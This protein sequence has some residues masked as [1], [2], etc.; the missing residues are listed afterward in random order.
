MRFM[1]HRGSNNANATRLLGHRRRHSATETAGGERLKTPT[2]RQTVTAFRHYFRE[3]EPTL[4]G[5]KF[6]ELRQEL[7]GDPMRM[8]MYIFS[9]ICQNSTST[10]TPTASPQWVADDCPNTGALDRLLFHANGEL[11]APESRMP[12]LRGFLQ[13]L[14]ELDAESEPYMVAGYDFLR[15]ARFLKPV[16]EVRIEFKNTLPRAFPVLQG[17]PDVLHW[18]AC[19]LLERY[20]PALLRTDLEELPYG[21][22]EFT[23]VQA[24]IHLLMDANLYDPSLGRR[25]I[26]DTATSLRAAVSHHG[27]PTQEIL[28]SQMHAALLHARAAG[29]TGLRLPFTPAS[30]IAA[31]QSLHNLQV[32]HENARYATLRTALAYLQ[33]APPMRRTI[34][35]ALLRSLGADPF[36]EG[37]ADQRIDSCV[38][39]A[40]SL[41]DFYM[42]D[43][44]ESALDVLP[45]SLKRS[46]LP[47]LNQA[48]DDAFDAWHDE[49]KKALG[50]ILYYGVEE[51]A[52]DD[53]HFFHDNEV[54]LLQPTLTA[55]KRLPYVSPTFSGDPSNY[56]DVKLSGRRG[57][58][59]AADNGSERRYFQISLGER[60]APIVA[61]VD[62]KD[63]EAYIDTHRGEF[64]EQDALTSTLE[65][66]LETRTGVDV[67]DTYAKGSNAPRFSRTGAILASFVRKEIHEFGY[68]RT[69]HRQSVEEIKEF[70]LGFVPGYE[71]VTKALGENPEEAVVP[72]TADGLSIVMPLLSRLVKTAAALGRLPAKLLSPAAI[73]QLG[74]AFSRHGTTKVLGAIAQHLQAPLTK[75]GKDFAYGMGKDLLRI[76]DP[77][78]E[79]SYQV[80]GEIRKLYSLARHL[81][82]T[83][84]IMDNLIR[85]LHR[86]PHTQHT[87][88]RLM[89]NRHQRH[90]QSHQEVHQQVQQSARLSRAPISPV[91]QARYEG[92]MSN[93]A[94]G[95]FLHFDLPPGTE[96]RAMQ[97]L[98]Y[99]APYNELE[100][101]VVLYKIN[102]LIYAWDTKRPSALVKVQTLLSERSVCR[103]PRDGGASCILVKDIAQNRDS[104]RPGY[105][106]TFGR[107][108]ENIC[109]L[110]PGTQTRTI[111]TPTL[112]IYPETI[113]IA[114]QQRRIVPMLDQPYEVTATAGGKPKLEVISD[115]WRKLHLG[116]SDTILPATG[117][118]ISYSN[119]A[120][121][122][123]YAVELELKNGPA[124]CEA[125]A[126]YGSYLAADGTDT[127]I[128]R[129]MI[130]LNGDYVRIDFPDPAARAGDVRLAKA[131]PD[132]IDIYNQFQ[133][134]A[135]AK[136]KR[137][138]SKD[139]FSLTLPPDGAGS[140]LRLYRHYN[141]TP[142]R[143]ML[144]ELARLPGLNA[145]RAAKALDRYIA[146][147]ANSAQL[148]EFGQI[149]SLADDILGRQH[150]S[151][152]SALTFKHHLAD[153]IRQK[154]QRLDIHALD[155]ESR[156]AERTLDNLATIFP[157]IG[158]VRDRY[159][160]KLEAAST[161]ASNAQF[162]ERETLKEIR[163]ALRGRNPAYAEVR[164]PV[165][166][167]MILQKTYFSV[168][169]KQQ[170]NPK[171]YQRVETISPG[172]RYIDA[173]VAEAASRGPREGPAHRFPD[174][175]RNNNELYRGHDA[176]HLLL[177]AIRREYPASRAGRVNNI[178][179]DIEIVTLVEPCVMCTLDLAL[180]S[181]AYP[182]ANLNVVFVTSS[183]DAADAGGIST[184]A[185]THA[186]HRA[187]RP[188]GAARQPGGRRPRSI[189]Q[190][191]GA[192]QFLQM[193]ADA[194]KLPFNE[195]EA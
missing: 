29:N 189:R 58:L 161:P 94:T 177:E 48:Y 80:L 55:S 178:A 154:N 40:K 25:E 117:K 100:D 98:K 82:I 157:A 73:R 130:R 151:Y 12:M 33:T 81:A 59:F 90:R 103:I 112:E 187:H 132:E 171:G 10:S 23:L 186:T 115:D 50:V 158:A 79:M 106:L 31:L 52:P 35:Q 99:T 185:N 128:Y 140:V 124:K 64:F 85:Q 108:Q 173:N 163:K 150:R 84:R 164:I 71:C 109:Q 181:A 120:D 32:D 126:H 14:L 137:S 125:R 176:E 44:T 41:L 3:N 141:L 45:P 183:R 1:Q 78:F 179:C 131:T 83:P 51:L 193:L 160:A 148:A 97:T 101:S 190:T 30:Y 113:T 19:Q 68:E 7:F 188:R 168:S 8:I 67:L 191:A 27:V 88:R 53:Y 102:D 165:D 87:A 15:D 110:T 174:F 169:G 122:K 63:I 62:C 182:N 192:G 86:N 104:A 36:T 119:V 2:H 91:L 107:R 105:Q 153:A 60:D 184:T 143:D 69:A 6:R 24:D 121:V 77:G 76:G 42:D 72:C 66:A 170:G 34:A 18:L 194:V 26:R 155:P 147:P 21:Q 65:D 127:Q 37:R 159:L 142:Y 172:G 47:D 195:M 167:R 9:N 129:G 145:A 43:C 61:P 118:L 162:I 123:L 74:E 49:Y 93:D 152:S 28:L 16:A 135:L 139:A 89:H 116:A 156:R 166:G 111:A 146:D 57:L 175:D 56:K 4:R 95:V 96:A 114:K 133:A 134:E 13:R 54:E 39:Q 38:G 11:P 92:L 180:F 22:R 138:T 75:I 136:Y 46:A 149:K 5:P 144:A 70:L 20:D 17:H